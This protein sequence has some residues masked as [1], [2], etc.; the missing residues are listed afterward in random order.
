MQQGEALSPV[1]ESAVAEA[2]F[3]QSRYYCDL[4]GGEL[5]AAHALVPRVLA[6]GDACGEP[7]WAAGARQL[8]ADLLLLSGEGERARHMLDEAAAMCKLAD[9]LM[10]PLVEVKRAWC[11]LLQGES[12]A[13][14]E[15]LMALGALDATQPLEARDTRRHVEAGIALVLGDAAQALACVPDPAAA[16]TEEAKALQWA[17]RVQAEAR[18]GGAAPAT[19]QAIGSLLASQR[20]PPLEA[21]VLQRALSAAQSPAAPVVLR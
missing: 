1:Y 11:E 3:L 10:R 17:M 9:G 4:L 7:Y 12:A 14:R 18:G 5:E 6:T 20:V 15:R 16:S 2:A 21:A 19:R 13:A 8:V